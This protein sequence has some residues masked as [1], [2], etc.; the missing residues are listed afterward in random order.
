MQNK[1]ELFRK[2]RRFSDRRGVLCVPEK[3]KERRKP[4]KTSLENKKKKLTAFENKTE[5]GV[6]WFYCFTRARSPGWS[7]G[8]RNTYTWHF[9]HQQSLLRNVRTRAQHD[10]TRNRTELKKFSVLNIHK[11][12]FR[13]VSDRTERRGSSTT[14][15]INTDGNGTKKKKKKNELFQKYFRN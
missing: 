1:A 14:D 3:K 9:L 11:N 13:V 12:W 6:S 4:V 2:T 15:W 10:A 7:G 8:Q 5:R